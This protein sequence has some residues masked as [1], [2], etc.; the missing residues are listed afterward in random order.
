MWFTALAA[1]FTLQVASTDAETDGSTASGVGIV[2]GP[3]FGADYM[4]M[5]MKISYWNSSSTSSKD[6][7]HSVM[8]KCENN[9]NK[10]AECCAWTYVMPGGDPVSCAAIDR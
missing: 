2:R 1:L 9:C 10:D 7:Y 4:G 8:L 5:D 3:L 6:H